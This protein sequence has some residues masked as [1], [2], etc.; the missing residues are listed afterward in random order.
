MTPWKP[1]TMSFGA[2]LLTTGILV[3]VDNGAE[4]EHL[5]IAYLFP[6]ALIAVLYGSNFAFLTSSASAIAATYFFLPPKFSLYVAKP[7]HIAELGFF[8][9][10]ALI[11]GKIVSLLTHD[12]PLSVPDARNRD[13]GGRKTSR[14]LRAADNS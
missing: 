14:Q 3:A 2:V 10:T 4:L 8:V 6:I 13:Q 7:L 9:V 5:E 11:A 12:A 1:V